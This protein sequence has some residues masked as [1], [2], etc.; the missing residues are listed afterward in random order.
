MWWFP[1][2]FRRLF[3]TDDPEEETVELVFENAATSKD[4]GEDGSGKERA[5]DGLDVERDRQPDESEHERQARPHSELS[6]GFLIPIFFINV[7]L[8]FEISLLQNLDVLAKAFAVIGA[9]FIVKIVPSLVFALRGFFASGS[10][11]RRHAPIG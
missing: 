3:S 2:R 9:A 7:G 1:E 10:A 6:Y 8:R 5:E 11:G 4:N